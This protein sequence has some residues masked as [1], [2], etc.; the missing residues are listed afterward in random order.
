MKQNNSCHYTRRDFM[1]RVGCGLSTM[2]SL[3]LYGTASMKQKPNI[4]WICVEDMSPNMSCYGETTIETPNID[5]LAREGAHFTQAFITCPVCSPSRSA[6]VT[7]MYQ[8]TIGAHNHRSSRHE[9][10]IH[11]PEHIRL[12]PDY[13]QHAGYYTSNGRMIPT[14][15]QKKTQKGKTDYNFVFD[16]NVY[17]GNDWFDR[18]PGQPFF[19]QL[20]L[21]GGKNRGAKVPNPVDPAEVKLPPYY[22]DHPVLREDWANYLNSVIQTDIEV[23]QILDRL[24]QDGDLD[25]TIIFFWTDHG[26]SHVRDKQFLYEGGIHIPLI[27]RGPGIE[28]G[29]VIGNLT[30]HIDIPFTSF[31]LAGLPVPEHLQGRFLFGD[32]SEPRE[33]IFSARDRCDETVERIRCVRSEQFK[34]IRNYYPD[35]PHAQPN[36]YKDGKQIMKTM[37][38]LY[39]KG[40]LTPT[41]ARPFLP[42]RPSEE[43][44]DLKNDPYEM[45]NLT[46][47]AEHRSKLKTF[48][49]ELTKWMDRTKDLGQIPEPL[50]AELSKHYDSYWAILQ[51]KKN[52][53]MVKDL[54]EMYGLAEKG[55]PACDP[56]MKALQDDRS[57]VRY[58]AAMELSKLGEEGKDAKK[59]LQKSLSDPSASVRVAAARAVA[60]MGMIEDARKVL[61]DELQHSDNEIVRHY[62]ACGLEDMGEEARPAYEIIKKARE[63]EYEYVK[64]V[65]T[66][67]IQKLDRTE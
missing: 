20:Q 65:T 63:D 51:D 33:Y 48:R 25:N 52:Q 55:E 7:G 61:A 21:R 35:R 3:S 13:F 37:R 30:E 34:Y 11:L 47:S 12:I 45:N 39:E 10:K 38:E 18:E 44:Y 56:L 64:R 49:N 29:T 19:A 59:L 1:K 50:L 5:R 26:I 22:P 15:P 46:E 14:N 32:E 43:L 23:G 27:V 57:T 41:Q 66:R 8:T 28:A 16:P 4:L 9:E 2:A 54:R 17:D 60:E 24:E 67:I 62:A 6:M 58:V 42:T 36:R 40:K 31:E 53:Q